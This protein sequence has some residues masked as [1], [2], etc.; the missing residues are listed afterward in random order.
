ML[1]LLTLR[2]TPTIYYGEEI[3]MVDVPVAAADSRD[4][5]ERRE[6]GRGRDPERSPMQ[7]DASPNAGLHAARRNAVAAARAGRAIAS[8]LPDRR[9]I[10]TRS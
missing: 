4:P 7:W 5:L 8:T 10:P 3:G 1:L 6:P 2:G 9:R